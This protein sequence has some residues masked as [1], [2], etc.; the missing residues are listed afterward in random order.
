M[1]ASLNGLKRT[2]AANK[3]IEKAKELGLT[4]TSAYRS[5]E[6]DK[7]VGGTGRGY[8]TLGQALDV[9][10][11]KAKMDAYAKWAKGSGL[12]RSVLWQVAGHYDHVHVSWDAASAEKWGEPT[13]GIVNNGDK[14]GI[15]EAIQKLLGSIN[16][17]GY[18]GDQ[19]EAAVKQFQ[20]NEA[21]Q[22]DGIVG[23]KTWEKLTGGGASF[24]S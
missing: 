4:I 9:A 21:L 18:F 3:A 23:P 16:I 20:K 22:Q 7:R 15:V 8:H 10:G 24:F 5:P 2:N 6:H 11:S 13:N 19:T 17:D 1:A 12:F 14:G